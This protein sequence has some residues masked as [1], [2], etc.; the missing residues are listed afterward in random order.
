MVQPYGGGA[1]LLCWPWGP[2]TPP[3]GAAKRP[4]SSASRPRP[5][6]TGANHPRQGPE[7][8]S[9][10]ERGMPAHLRRKTKRMQRPA[11]C[12]TTVPVCWS[13]HQTPPR[14]GPPRPSA[15]GAPRPPLPFQPKPA[16][17][18]SKS[19]PE[20]SDRPWPAWRH[21]ASTDPVWPAR[22]AFPRPVLRCPCRKCRRRQLQTTTT[23]RWLR[24]RWP[25]QPNRPTPCC[26]PP[27]RWSQ[28]STRPPRHCRVR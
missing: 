6:D 12:Q 5:G 4:A 9:V 22:R 15:P 17:P 23:A 10:V 16:P 20:R 3:A 7:S 1:H 26:M 13:S 14:R 11:T 19:K 21:A 24:P 2:A 28:R 27:G 8:L 25:G 18:S